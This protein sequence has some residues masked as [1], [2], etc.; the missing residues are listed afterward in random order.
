MRVNQAPLN[1]LRVS[2]S[3]HSVRGSCFTET[4][5]PAFKAFVTICVVFL[6]SQCRNSP[7]KAILTL[8][9]LL[10]SLSGNIH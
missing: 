2:L 5:R 10:A 9:F 8:D 4:L 3:V 1:C 7:S 6:E